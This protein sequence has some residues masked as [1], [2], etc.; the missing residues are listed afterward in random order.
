MAAAVIAFSLF[1]CDE[2]KLPKR[3]ERAKIPP[4]AVKDKPKKKFTM[5]P[6]PMH[7]LKTT[8]KEMVKYLSKMQFP[9]TKNIPP[10]TSNKQCGWFCQYL[11]WDF[12]TIAATLHERVTQRKDNMKL[13]FDEAMRMVFHIKSAFYVTRGCKAVISRFIGHK[14]PGTALELLRN[15]EKP[16]A[17]DKK[18]RK[19]PKLLKEAIKKMKGMASVM[20]NGRTCRAKIFD[21]LGL[22]DKMPNTAIELFRGISERKLRRKQ[23]EKM[24]D[25]LD[26]FLQSAQIK[27]LKAFDEHMSSAIRN[28][29]TK[30]RLHS[31]LKKETRKDSFKIFAS[32]GRLPGLK[33]ECSCKISVG[34]GRVKV[35]DCWDM[36][37]LDNPIDITDITCPP[38]KK[39]LPR[40]PP[41]WKRTQV[42]LKSKGLLKPHLEATEKMLK[43]LKSRKPLK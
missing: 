41:H 26:R 9:P 7:T 38:S 39:P 8:T 29:K 13:T 6:P 37:D 32:K 21:I 16:I 31:F 2:P 20:L 14:T 5:P 33:R 4:A 23:A 22:V 18:V 27:D 19:S 43:S 36:T 25:Y 40:M 42:L 28:I 11:S 10:M 3:L 15:M 1:S 35:R 24:A 17:K 12:P 30:R 34:S